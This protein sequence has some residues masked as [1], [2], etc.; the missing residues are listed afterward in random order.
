MEYRGRVYLPKSPGCCSFCGTHWWNK[1]KNDVESWM[2]PSKIPE[3]YC[4]L[5]SREIGARQTAHQMIKSGH[6][7][8]CFYLAGNKYLLQMLLKLPVLEQ[9]SSHEAADIEAK[10]LQWWIADLQIHK[11]SPEY[12]C[13]VEKSKKR[14]HEQR[15]LSQQIWK[16]S[17]ELTTAK[18]LAIRRDNG[19]W[20]SLTRDEQGLVDTFDAGKLHRRLQNLVEEKIPIYRGSS[21]LVA[22]LQKD[23]QWCQCRC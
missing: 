6:Y 20:G 22:D 10:A 13:A 3:Y 23:D 7:S 14:S 12:K 5:H 18:I 9:C 2:R 15:R 19:E 17:R 1:W 21:A 8:Y 4:V 16:L 11:E